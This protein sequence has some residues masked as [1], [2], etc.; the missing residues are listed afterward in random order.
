MTTLLTLAKNFNKDNHWIT[1]N[2]M[3]VG[4]PPYYSRL[5]WCV[6]SLGYWGRG[7]YQN[8][9]VQV[10][11]KIETSSRDVEKNPNIEG[12]L[13]TLKGRMGKNNI[14]ASQTLDRAL[15]LLRIPKPVFT[16]EDLKTKI[17]SVKRFDM[18][19]YK[20][21]K[22]AE[23]EKKYKTLEDL[24]STFESCKSFTDAADH[25]MTTGTAL[26][27]ILPQLFLGNEESSG[28][29]TFSY[30]VSATVRHKT[31]PLQQRHQ[32]PQSNLQGKDVDWVDVLDMDNMA[33]CIKAIHKAI[34][35]KKIVLV[36]CQKGKDLSPTIVAAYLMWRFNV[37]AVQAKDYIKHLRPIVTFDMVEIKRTLKGQ[38]N[39]STWVPVTWLEN[40]AQ[41]I[42]DIK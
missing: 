21:E 8:I 6:I 5:F 20:V 14:E 7:Y 16:E 29:S 22:A 26:N 35:E 28:D 39:P 34:N 40:H 23:L 24:P 15:N 32:I 9:M 19:A 30:V 3:L 31:N 33:V 4:K 18:N 10:A 1:P 42:Y 27:E 13:G 38:T 11:K 37:S 25:F 12:F 17:I 2:L 36:H 41:E